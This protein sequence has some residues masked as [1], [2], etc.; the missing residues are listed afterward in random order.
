M[1]AAKVLDPTAQIDRTRVFFGATVTI[2]DEHDEMRVVT[3]V[4]DEEADA[5]IG[6]LGWNSPLAKAVRGSSVGDVRTVHLPGGPKEW[7]VV[8]ISYPLEE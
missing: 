3:L 4:G 7:E 5:G 2:A 1:K 6:L 8:R